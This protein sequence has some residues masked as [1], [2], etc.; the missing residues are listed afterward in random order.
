MVMSNGAN[1]IILPP[2]DPVNP[3]AMARILVIAGIKEAD[4]R[5]LLRGIH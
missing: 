2:G 3:Y 1:E 4:F 5:E